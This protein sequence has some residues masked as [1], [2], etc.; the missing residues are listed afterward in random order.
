M[1][2]NKFEEVKDKV[3]GS[4]KETTG[5]VIDNDEMELKGKLQK[6]LGKARELAGDVVD[7]MDD[8]KDKVIGTVK[9]VT[10]KFTDDEG[11]ELKGKLQKDKATSPNTNKILGGI[12]A[13]AGLYALKSMFKRRK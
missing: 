7:E 13:L 2:E 4:V 6:G 9:E 8:V 10:G 12:G 1:N 5:K 11:L 3:V